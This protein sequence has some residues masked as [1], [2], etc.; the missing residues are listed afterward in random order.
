ME[1]LKLGCVWEILS[2]LV[3]VEGGGAQEAAGSG[4]GI[5]SI[6]ITKD[7]KCQAKEL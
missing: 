4:R 5:C 2:S 3:W 6:Q 1:T 7:L